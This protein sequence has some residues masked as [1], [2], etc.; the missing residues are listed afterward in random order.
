MCRSKSTPFR[1]HLSSSSGDS[2]FLSTR[3]EKGTGSSI[4]EFAEE[5]DAF[6]LVDEEFEANFG[7]VE[8]DFGVVEG[9]FGVVDADFGVVEADFGVVEADF[10]VVE[11]DFEA[12]T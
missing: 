8:G 12:C 10:G 9:D 3:E 2:L 4:E 11:A 1:W 7:V 6:R 5:E